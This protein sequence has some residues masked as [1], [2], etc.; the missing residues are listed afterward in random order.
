MTLGEGAFGTVCRV[1]ALVSS[2]LASNDNSGKRIL[3]EGK[4][5]NMKNLSAKNG[6]NTEEKNRCLIAD[7]LYVI[8]IID[9]S[10]IPKENAYEALIEVEMLQ[11]IDYSF[12]VGY[13][14][15]FI[16]GQQINI[17]MEYCHHHDLSGYIKKQNGKPFVENFVWKVFIQIALG[18]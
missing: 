15:S 3:L 8:K 1:K 2:I 7:Q 5:Q 12:I 18:V 4:S 9:T 6:P 17:I 16:E 14:D 13:I 10:K 11:K